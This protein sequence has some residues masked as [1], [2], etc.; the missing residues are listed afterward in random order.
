MELSLPRPFGMML[1]LLVVVMMLAATAP[2]RA[3]LEQRLPTAQQLQLQANRRADCPIF[4]VCSTWL[5][6]NRASCTG[7][8]LFSIHTGVSNYMQVLDLSNNSISQ[9]EDKGLSRAGLTKL[10]FLNLSMNSISEIGMK[11]FDDL[12]AL[13]VLDL[14]MNHIDFITPD[15]FIHNM[16]LK[17]L[18]LSGNKFNLQVPVLHSSSITDLD[19]SGCRINSLP[20]DTF[21]GLKQLRKLNLSNNKLIGLDREVLLAMP[22]LQF[23]MLGR[24]PWLCDFEFYNLK[25]AIRKA[26]IRMDPVCER[27]TLEAKFEEIIAKTS[28]SD[29]D[30]PIIIKSTKRPILVP[31]AELNEHTWDTESWR[32]FEEALRD[33]QPPM[34]EPRASN[35][36]VATLNNLSPFWFLLTGFLFGSVATMLFTYLWF[37]DSVTCP[38][39]I[40]SSEIV[41]SPEVNSQR[42]SLLRHLWQQ[43]NLP[44]SD[45]V[46]VRGGEGV[47]PT[48]FL[49]ALGATVPTCPG[50]PP[51]P[52]REVMLH[53]NLYPRAAMVAAA[54]QASGRTL[55]T[56]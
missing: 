48:V 12:R 4:C 10:K 52:Y 39:R 3:Q 24:N 6:L 47:G 11:A 22:S 42:V 15:T 13:V 38:R 8:G 36:F 53:C 23:L 56:E 50:T 33:E 19:L 46:S 2:T 32:E 40:R 43:E 16:E 1:G 14:S 5:R 34:A 45:E 55:S 44:S 26:D 37:S 18:N 31:R 9:L 29:I 41:N 35:V 21:L 27:P 51:P 30:E 17:I 28:E 54:Q 7:K 25:V 49:P 20:T